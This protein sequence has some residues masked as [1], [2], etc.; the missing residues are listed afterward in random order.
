MNVVIGCFVIIILL[1]LYVRQ[2]VK[3]AM[4]LVDNIFFR[5]KCLGTNTNKK[6]GGMGINRRLE[7]GMKMGT[8]MLIEM[9]LGDVLGTSQ[10]FSVSS[11]ICF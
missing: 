5:L 4:F 11:I 1:L 10:V 7:V 8:G 3:H 2:Y 6:P 9:G